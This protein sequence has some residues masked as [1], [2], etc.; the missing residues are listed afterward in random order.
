MSVDSIDD[1]YVDSKR[2][3]SLLTDWHSLWW[4]TFKTIYQSKS[5]SRRELLFKKKNMSYGFEMGVLKLEQWQTANLPNSPWRRVIWPTGDFPMKSQYQIKEYQECRLFGFVQPKM[6]SGHSQRFYRI[7]ILD[8]PMTMVL[9][10]SNIDFDM[11]SLMSVLTST[12][13]KMWWNVLRL[14]DST[15]E[16]DNMHVYV[17]VC[18]Y[19]YVYIY[20]YIWQSYTPL[21]Y[22][23]TLR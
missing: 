17:Y 10:C 4:R 5:P 9:L 11:A 22:S 7:T 13:W 1:E 6:L 2:T 20:I 8:I 21:L 18:I 3:I 14:I 16:C 23:I 19:I 15:N 12:I